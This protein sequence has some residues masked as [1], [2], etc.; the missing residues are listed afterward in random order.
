[1]IRRSVDLWVRGF[2]FPLL[3][4]TAIA[5]LSAW[6]RCPR[7]I[8]H[9]IPELIWLITRTA[10][11]VW[12]LTISL[13]YVLV[14]FFSRARGSYAQ[15]YS[16]AEGATSA[17]WVKVKNP[18]GGEE[19]RVAQS[20]EHQPSKLRVAGSSPAAPTISGEACA[21]N[22]QHEPRLPPRGWLSKRRS[23]PF[24]TLSKLGIAPVAPLLGSTSLI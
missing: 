3:R 17:A 8:L 11:P 1:M 15:K 6:C 4:A 16:L 24:G 14:M 2:P 19:R 22:Y 7:G 9:G 5:R 12:G 21:Q 13:I 23:K 18:S 20:I 10:H